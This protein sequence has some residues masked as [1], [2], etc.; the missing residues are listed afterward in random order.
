LSCVPSHFNIN[1]DGLTMP[2]K[3]PSG[4]SKCHGE[5]GR[6]KERNKEAH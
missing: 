1:A 2:G 5:H 4:P 3:A 6:G